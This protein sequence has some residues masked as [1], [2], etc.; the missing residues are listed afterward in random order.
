[1]RL[2]STGQVHLPRNVSEL[3]VLIAHALAPVLLI[4]A[5]MEIVTS[6]WP[7][8]CGLLAATSMGS[9]GYVFVRYDAWCRDTGRQRAKNTRPV[10]ASV[11]YAGAALLVIGSFNTHLNS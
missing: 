1:M 9:L 11:L 3:L 10:V 6:R 2:P 7:G 4:L 8:L 5:L